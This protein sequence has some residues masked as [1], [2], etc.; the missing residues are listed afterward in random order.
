MKKVDD[1]GEAVEGATYKLELKNSSG[2]WEEV[3]LV[4]SSTNKY[5]Y[6]AESTDTPVVATTNSGGTV[7]MAELDQG[8]YRLTE[9]GTGSGLSL[10]AD[11]IEVTLPYT[12]TTDAKKTSTFTTTAGEGEDAVITYYFCDVTFDIR[13][14]QVIDMPAAGALTGGFPWTTVGCGLAVFGGAAA[15][16]IAARRRQAVLAASAGPTRARHI[17]PRDRRKGVPRH[18]AK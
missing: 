17:K 4:Y 5:Y 15:V 8:T 9:T 2:A 10:L 1:E 3:K 16:A 7:K 14:D 18:A 12:S 6:P 13:N 11:Y